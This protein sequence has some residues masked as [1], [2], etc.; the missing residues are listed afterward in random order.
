MTHESHADS[1]PHS[2]S[3][4]ELNIVAS[5]AMMDLCLI[6]SPP[7]M[8]FWVVTTVF[9]YSMSWPLLGACAG[10]ALLLVGFVRFRGEGQRSSFEKYIIAA[11][12]ADTWQETSSSET[13]DQCS[14]AATHEEN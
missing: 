6:A 1:D 11:Q 9:D 3:D 4:R 12:G 8:L 7:M 10:L 14:A 5:L 13:S 2:N